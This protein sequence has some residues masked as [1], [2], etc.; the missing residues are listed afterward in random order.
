[1]KRQVSADHEILNLKKVIRSHTNA[2]VFNSVA[3]CDHCSFYFF[4]F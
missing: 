2:E 1:M 4:L 3:S